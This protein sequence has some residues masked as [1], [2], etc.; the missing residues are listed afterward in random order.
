MTKGVHLRLVQAVGLALVLLLAVGSVPSGPQEAGADFQDTGPSNAGTE[1]NP[2]ADTAADVDADWWS[3]VQEGILRSEYHVTWQEGTYLDEVPAAYQAPN[4]AQDLRTYFTPQGPLAI[5]R[6]GIEPGEGPPWRWQA[7]LVGWGRAGAMTVVPEAVLA[8][9]ENRIEY[10]RGESLVEWYRNDEEGLAQGLTLLDAP[11]GGEPGEPLQ[12]ELALGGDLV[13]DLADG[14]VAIAFGTASG[15]HTLRYG[16]LRASDAQGQPLPAW[17]SLDGA[18]LSICIEDVGA[19]YPIEVQANLR[20]LLPTWDW[21]ITFGQEGAQFGTSLATAGDVDGDGYSDVIVGAPYYDGGLAEEGGAFVYYGYRDGLSPVA[22][23]YNTGGQAGAHYGWSAATAGDVNGDGLADVIVGAPGYTNTQAEEGGI[24]IYHGAAAGLSDGAARHKESNVANAE[25]GSSVATAG[26]V[27]GDGYADIIVGAPDYSASHV[28]EGRVYVWHGGSGGI[29]AG[30]A[31][32]TAES[33]QTG[34]ALGSC[35]ATAGDVDGDGYADVIVGA[36][37]Y[38]DTRLNEGAA[39]VWHGSATGVNGGTSGNPTNADWTFVQGQQGA[40]MGISVSTAGDVNGDGYA[41]VIVGAHLY[42]FSWI[43][44]GGA[45]LFLGSETGLASDWD[46]FDYGNQTEAWFGYSVATAGDVNGDGYADVIVGAPLYTTDVLEEGRAWVWHGS[47]DGIS[48]TRDWYA[49]GE[50]SQAWYGTSV[51][52]A[53]DVNGDGYS[54]VIVGAPGH[55]SK[56]GRA[57]MYPGLPASLGETAGWT[58]PRSQAGALYGT[59]VGT[60]GDVNG[61]GYADVIVGAPRWDSAKENEGAAWVYLGQ[62]EGLDEIPHFYKR[63][64]NAGAEFGASVGTAGDVDGNGYDD[65]IVG[66][67]GW[68]VPEVEEGAAF[69]YAGSADGL[70]EDAGPLW[71]KPSDQAG[72][73]F[74]T[75][76]GTAGDV[77]GDGYMDI[78]VGAPKWQSSG[79]ERGAVWLYYGSDAG[80]HSAPDWYTPGDQAEAQYGYAVGTAGDVN[81]DG[82]SDVVVGSPLWEDDVVN[83]GRAWAYLGSPSGLRHDVHWHAEGNNFNAQM[84]RALGTAGDVDGDGYSDVIVGAPY[85]GDDGLEGEGKVWAFHGS[86]DGLESA[87]TWS[88]EGGQNSAHYGW[89]VGT[90]GD[91]NGDGYA[92]VIIGIQNWS[93]GQSFE[94]AASVYHGA[95]RGL[96]ASWSWRQESDDISAHYGY[97]VGTAGDVNGDGYA[98]VIVGAPNY[99]TSSELLDEGRAFLYYGNDGP[100]VSLRPRQ[101]RAAQ[102]LVLGP[103]AHLGTSSLGRGFTLMATMRTPF[104]RGAV[105]PEFEVKSL[106]TSFDGNN[107]FAPGVYYNVDPGTTRMTTIWD[108]FPGAS[109]HWRLRIC[110]HPATT[111]WMPCSRWLTVPWNG[112]NEK[113][114][115]TRGSGILLPLVLKDY[116]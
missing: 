85:Y 66:A 47:A 21:A 1:V 49:D 48:T 104:G 15:T 75:S 27:N 84:G 6:T 93:G 37:G 68:N 80:P 64:N 11:P 16:G 94:G 52:T 97:S 113:D 24:W 44:E 106:G 4:R 55:A 78:I 103:I 17:L 30:D 99:E 105:M 112:W 98:D 46:N 12:L 14:G 90:A 110:Y 95:R 34:G 102:G 25:F 72:A 20:G 18:T 83:E 53:G 36:R 62:A 54:E 82:Y 111:P 32:W 23:W 51:A 7:S 26:D 88:K 40:G 115:R 71:N 33:N 91:V 8:A 29:P 79:E 114:L 70:D 73:R 3:T 5:P 59:A 67:P 77:N 69:V 60:A 43:D 63:S 39:F 35:V 56:A 100:G 10:R 45:W 58:K 86:A 50:M 81:G 107:T 116:P 76:V 13:P 42:D 74:G 65:I 96:E 57:Y 41:D 31:H 9:Q 109:Y 28:A 89:S 19:T 101:V 2:P 38:D 92:D 22:D 108:L 61:D 87:A